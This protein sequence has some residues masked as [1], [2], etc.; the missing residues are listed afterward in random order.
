MI[1]FWK[2]T[3]LALMAALLKQIQER[4]QETG[5]NDL[6]EYSQLYEIQSDHQKL[7]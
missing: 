7:K 4:Q 3:T 1:I 6:L 5:H 2:N